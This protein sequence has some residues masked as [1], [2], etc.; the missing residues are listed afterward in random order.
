MNEELVKLLPC[1]FCGG[2]PTY[3][4][5]PGG[6]W[7]SV[8]C[9]DGE[10]AGFGG[11]RHRLNAKYAIED[12]NRRALTAQ[13]EPACEKCGMPLV[14][15]CQVCS[16]PWPTKDS[17]PPSGVREGMREVERVANQAVSDLAQVYG[18][19][20]EGKFDEAEDYCRGAA[21][22]YTQD[23]TRASEGK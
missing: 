9:A 1:P 15:G 4:E 21:D 11:T 8:Q 16:T 20:Q 18:L 5:Y 23:I 17:T 13:Q 12:W 22:G 2:T 14:L 6:Y 10:C 19:L 7:H 3:T